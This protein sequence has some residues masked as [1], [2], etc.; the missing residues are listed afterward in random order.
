MQTGSADPRRQYQVTKTG[1]QTDALHAGNEG[2]DLGVVVDRQLKLS[3]HVKKK[4]NAGKQGQPG[5]G[6][7]EM[8][9]LSFGK[10][11]FPQLVQVSLDLTWSL[12][13][14]PGAQI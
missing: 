6:S 9:L 2:R 5:P 12:P 8:H 10:K 7:F 11:G 13:Q 4:K 1:S 14:Q 3:T